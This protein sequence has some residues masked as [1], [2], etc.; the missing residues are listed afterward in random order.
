MP[1][2][3][4]LTFLVYFI[5]W[6]LYDSTIAP[7]SSKNPTAT[8]Q[9]DERLVISS[10]QTRDVLIFQPAESGDLFYAFAGRDIVR[11]GTYTDFKPFFFL[12]TTWYLVDWK[13]KSKPISNRAT[14]LFALSPNSIRDDDFMDF[15][16]VVD[17]ILCMPVWSYNDME[18]CRAII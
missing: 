5:I 1:G 13:P 2:I 10:G 7:D 14:S 18:K 4:K 17:M 9:N 8:F 16:K 11:T 3:G 15:E 6:Y 12:N